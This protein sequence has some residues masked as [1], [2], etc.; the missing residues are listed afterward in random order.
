ML[1]ERILSALVLAPLAIGAFYLGGIAFA[2]LITILALFASSEYKRLLQG[3]D[4]ELN[5]IFIPLCAL[6]ALSGLSNRPEYL[7]ISVLLGTL[8]LLSLSS[9]QKGMPTAAFSVL[10]ITYIGGFFGTLALLRTSQ[11]GRQWAFLVLFATW[12]TD[13]F[14]FF[15][16]KAFGKHKLAPKVSP[17]KTWEGSGFGIAA[18]IL[19][20]VLWGNYV[21]LPFSFCTFAGVTLGFMAIV[22]DLVESSLK[23]YCKA[24]D[25]GNIIPGHGGILDRFDSLLFTGVWG[26]LL[27]SLWQIM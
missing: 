25:S 19:V 6:I 22:G 26:F 27:K 18:S 14:A 15:G 9:I 21:E 2:A 23:R 17:G 11:S 16:G 12:A 20:S 7:F 10:G 13:I 1:K 3:A 24:K 8:V 5:I 4:V